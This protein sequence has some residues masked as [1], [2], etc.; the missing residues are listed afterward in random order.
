MMLKVV[1]FADEIIYN[2]FHVFL[3]F[4][5]NLNNIIKNFFKM[6]IVCEGDDK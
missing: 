4:L 5:K 6:A 1:V 3:Y 2:Y